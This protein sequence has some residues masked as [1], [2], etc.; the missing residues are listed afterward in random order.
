MC[1][2]VQDFID[3]SYCW[4]AMAPTRSGRVCMVVGRQT[5]AVP[6]ESRL[7]GFGQVGGDDL[8]GRMV[9]PENWPLCV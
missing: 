4:Q 1:P 9:T 6:P 8:T 3:P 7:F 2:V 5:D